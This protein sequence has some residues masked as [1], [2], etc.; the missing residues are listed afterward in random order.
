MV[1]GQWRRCGSTQQRLRELS[2]GGI[3]VAWGALEVS[4]FPEHCVASIDGQPWGQ[5]DQKSKNHGTNQKWG[6]NA[7]LELTGQV[8]ADEA[9]KDNQGN[10]DNQVLH[11]GNNQPGEQKV[12][13]F[14]GGSDQ[15]HQM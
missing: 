15:K 8:E 2:I 6:P 10:A 12:G 5:G 13:L 4:A 3:S 7:E 14:E 9:E 1:G 11:Q